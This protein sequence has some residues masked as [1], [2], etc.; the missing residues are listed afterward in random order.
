MFGSSNKKSTSPTTSSSALSDS[1]QTTVLA[2]GT[3]MDG[4]FSCTE[5]VRLDG[6]IIG[7]VRVDK[8]LVMGE[9]G[10]VEGNIVAQDAVIK[11][12][13]VGDL[14]VQDSLQLVGTAVIEGNITAK[15]MVVEE[16]AR[17]NGTCKI[18]ANNAQSN[19]MAKKQVAAATA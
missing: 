7:E 11:G 10:V 12:R 8:R 16:G 13:I 18:G 1:G 6:K 3:T 4:K 19:G 2:K 15:T 17:Y 5:N 14:H 9:T